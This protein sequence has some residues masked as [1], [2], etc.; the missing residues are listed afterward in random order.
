MVLVKNDETMSKF[1]KVMP[2]KLPRLFSSGHYI[3]TTNNNC[4]FKQI[5]YLPRQTQ[6]QTQTN[7][8]VHLLATHIF[9]PIAV[10]TAG[11]GTNRL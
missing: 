11:S 1:V 5:P 7:K 10:K 2:R 6:R 4:K 8:Y 9:I 3:I